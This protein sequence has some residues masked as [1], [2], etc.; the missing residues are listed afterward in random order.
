[1]VILL[2]FFLQISHELYFS[3]CFGCCS[4]VLFV[5]PCVWQCFV[6]SSLRSMVSS[7]CISYYLPLGQ[8]KPWPL[9]ENY[10]SLPGSLPWLY[11]IFIACICLIMLHFIKLPLLVFLLTSLGFYALL[12][13]YCTSARSLMFPWSLTY[14]HFDYDSSVKTLGD[15]LITALVARVSSVF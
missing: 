14:K 7:I 4:S 10:T 9:L 12:Y 5:F 6:M 8:R 13:Y 15:Q 2:S 3:L 1:M 11:L